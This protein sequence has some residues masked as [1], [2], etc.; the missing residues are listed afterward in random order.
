MFLRESL[1]SHQSIGA[2]APTSAT[3]ARQMAGFISPDAALTV[4]ELGAGT[5]AISAAVGCRLGPDARHIAVE[6]DPTLLE[7]LHNAAPWAERVIGDAAQLSE[8]LA[9]VNV[10]SADVVI[11]SLPWGNFDPELQR[12]ILAEI[13]KV[14][15]P[16][17]VFAA[18]AY[19]PTRLTRG[20]RAF[21]AA[22]R[23]SFGEV[24]V[25]ST[26]WA[27]L[28]PA[29]LYVCRRPRRPIDPGAAPSA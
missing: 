2:I 24:V 16:D 25:T 13:T 8:R 7:A 12:R 3:A 17:G 9:E 15:T 11:S 28:P 6:R 4:V 22:L 14:L 26:L 23:A 18:I 19:R 21:R 5:G 29:R 10:P 27:N 1:R 20:S